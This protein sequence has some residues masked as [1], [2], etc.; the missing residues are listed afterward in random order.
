[1]KPAKAKKA[2]VNAKGKSAKPVNA[3]AKKKK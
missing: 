2:P 1:M 3:K